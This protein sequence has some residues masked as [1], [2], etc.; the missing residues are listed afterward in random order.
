ME[1]TQKKHKQNSK[2]KNEKET[3]SRQPPR[4]LITAFN[5]NI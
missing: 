2:D 3:D 1:H 4:I 5:C